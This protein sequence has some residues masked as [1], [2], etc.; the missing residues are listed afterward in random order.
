ML[1]EI[2]KSLKTK[3][4]L[5]NVSHWFGNN[6]VL[7][8]INL[9]ITAGQFVSIVGPSGCGK[10]TL[11]RTIVGTH[12]P[13]NGNVTIHYCSYSR[14]CLGPNRDIGIVYQQY[15]IY[16]FLTARKNV[17]I[18][19][20][21]DQFTIPRRILQFRKY[22]KFRKSAL[23]QAEDILIKVD[24]GSHLD[25]YPY[26]LSGGQKQRVAVAQSLIMKPQVL[27][28][29]EPFGALDEATREE[30]QM[31]LIG[32]YQ[33]NCAEMAKGKEPLYTVIIITHE[34]NE[35]LF[36]GDRV[37]AL[38][39]D[40]DWKKDFKECPG[41]TIVYDQ[42]APVFQPDVPKDFEKL[43]KQKLEIRSAISGHH[44]DKKY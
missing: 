8:N 7:H 33:E 23:K 39:R 19:L 1:G 38:S 30:L 36:V 27:L 11:L 21:F 41:A 31:L 4:V 14:E 42:P 24:L 16:D 25:R 3:L 2:K 15:P 37:V 28:L 34:L 18:G 5:N 20:D 6:Q 40:W 17:A 9:D 22:L 32:F 10:S 12:P 35:A 29:D 44:V 13:M 43:T 26:E